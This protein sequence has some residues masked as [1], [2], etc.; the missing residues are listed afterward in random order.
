MSEF[1]KAGTIVD[2]EVGTGPAGELRYPSYPET[3]GWSFPGIGEFQVL[4]IELRVLKCGFFCVNLISFFLGSCF[5]SAMTNIWQK[6]S[7]K[8]QQKQ[9]ILNGSYLLM[10]VNTMTPLKKQIFSEE[11]EL[12]KLIKVSSS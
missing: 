9:G 1:F 4:Y 8:Q 5:H 6:I 3:Q 11:M 7:R 10:L 12:T 2:I